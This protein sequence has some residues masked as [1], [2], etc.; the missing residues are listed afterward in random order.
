MVCKNNLRYLGRSVDQGLVS[1]RWDVY[2]ETS[3]KARAMS[4]DRAHGQLRDAVSVIF[5]IPRVSHLVEAID[6]PVGGRRVACPGRQRHYRMAIVTITHSWLPFFGASRRKQAHQPPRPGRCRFSVRLP[7]I[8]K[9]SC[10]LRLD[11]LAQK[12]SIGV[13]KAEE[14][15]NISAIQP[16]SL[17]PA[18]P[19]RV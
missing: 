17:Y 2:C 18:S 11:T 7:R 3:P 8:G 16:D 14:S 6:P 12:P 10:H 9:R 15:A 19:L 4:C 1:I 5:N 13:S